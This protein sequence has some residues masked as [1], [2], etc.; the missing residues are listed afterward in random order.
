VEFQ[1]L[2][3]QLLSELFSRA[4]GRL[5]ERNLSDVIAAHGIMIVTP[6]NWY[7][8]P[9]ALKAMIDRLVCVDGGN[10]DPSSTAKSPKKPRPWN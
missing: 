7:Q 2:A 9:T 5:D 4:G 8:A 1:S 6:L 3:V 10:P